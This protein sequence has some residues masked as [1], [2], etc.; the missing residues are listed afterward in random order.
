MTQEVRLTKFEI[1]SIVKIFREFFKS[2]DKIWLFGSRAD[3]QK[4]GGDI[5]LYIETSMKDY[6][7]AFEKKSAFVIKLQ[8]VIGD[9]KI[10]VVLDL[11]TKKALIYNIAK[12][13]GVRL[14]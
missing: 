14:I 13:T 5:D 4:K 1:V 6:D 7:E 2:N 9:Q 12:K 11:G 10:D 3:I 8:D